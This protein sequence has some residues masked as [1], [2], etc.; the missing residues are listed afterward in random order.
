MRIVVTLPWG[1]RL[2]GAE[3]MLQTVLDGA[4]GETHEL[5]PVFFQDGPWPR[6]LRD[7]GFAVEV[8]PTGRVR[9]AH[10]AAAAVARLALLLRRRRPDLVLNWMPKTQIYG[11]AAA[12]LAGI[13]GRVVW[14]QHGITAGHWTDRAATAVPA[15]AVGCSSHAAA[16]A[17]QGLRPRRQTFVVPPGTA[18]PAHGESTAAIDAQPGVP[19]VG[20]LGRLQPWKGQDRML[21]AQALLRERGVAMHLLI[22]G[23]DAYGLSPEYASS[24]PELARSLG[25]QDAVT[26]TGQLAEPGPYIERMDVLV[27]VSEGEPFGIVLLEAMARGV[28]VLAVDSGGPAEIVADGRSGILA[29]SGEPEAI[30]RALAPLLT[31]APLRERVARAGRERYEQMYTAEAMRARFFAALE[32]LASGEP[33]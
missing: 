22:V 33:G 19:V 4:R 28:A 8:I 32:R 15:L 10:R 17:Q 1:E 21:R 18:P 7:A 5:Q 20:I 31:D 16:R 3:T 13:P 2:G 23:G 14:W 9:E 29:P 27:N 30:A 26:M 12:T 24:L 6:E 25:L 11:G